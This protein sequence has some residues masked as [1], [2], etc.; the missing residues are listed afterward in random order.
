LPIEQRRN[1]KNAFDALA[2]IVREESV[3]TL[4]RGWQPTVARAMI[5]NA[6]QLG[7]Y[8]Q[9]KQGLLNTGWFQEGV[10]LHSAA[11]LISGFIS[12]AVSMPIDL[13]KTRLQTMK[14]NEY[15]VRSHCVPLV[16]LRSNF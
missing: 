14:N 7:T 13:T 5:L 10:A 6:A 11:S 9:A 8:S 2:R 12:T 3:G 15:S 16:Q 1:Y 4:W